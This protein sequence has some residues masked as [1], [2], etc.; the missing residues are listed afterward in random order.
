METVVRLWGLWFGSGDGGVT[1]IRRGQRHRLNVNKERCITNSGQ[2]VF[3]VLHGRRDFA[4][5]SGG[6]TEEAHERRGGKRVG[7][8]GWVTRGEGV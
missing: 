8:N 1:V 6:S 2:I 4:R 7:R 3:E 5:S